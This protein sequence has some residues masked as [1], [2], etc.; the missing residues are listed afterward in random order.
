M[1][2]KPK[3]VKPICY[4]ILLSLCSSSF[5]RGQK[6]CVQ[7]MPACSKHREL[8]RVILQLQ[9]QHCWLG[10]NYN[11]VSVHCIDSDSVFLGAWFTAIFF[12]LLFSPS[13]EAP[14]PFIAPS[15]PYWFLLQG[16][17]LM[18]TSVPFLTR[19][20]RRAG[21]FWNAKAFWWHFHA[22]WGT[23]L[24]QNLFGLSIVCICRYENFNLV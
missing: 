7:V 8:H 12:F 6:C 5:C 22:L 16:V 19:C 3:P 20:V 1:K 21:E 14:V 10:L 9:G 4:L 23:D 15:F 18:V 24:V 2:K 11:K 17:T 13:V